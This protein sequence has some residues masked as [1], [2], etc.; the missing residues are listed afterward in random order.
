[1]ITAVTV[2]ASRKA[3]RK[4]PANEKSRGD[5]DLR[6]HPDED[7]GKVKR[8][9][10]F[11]QQ[12]PGN[13]EDQQH[14]LEVGQRLLVDGVRLGHADEHRLQGEQ[15]AR[16]QGV[17]FRAMARVKMNSPMSTQPVMNGPYSEQV[18]G[19]AIR[20]RR[21]VNLYQVGALPRKFRVKAL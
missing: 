5:A 6:L 9:K 4:A 7:A 11:M 15:T 10:S 2:R 3:E 19:L 17:H 20:N 18:M 21:I 14:D 16:G 1:M 12:M 13:H 8:R